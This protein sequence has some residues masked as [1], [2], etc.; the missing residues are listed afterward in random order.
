VNDKR[1]RDGQDLDA[2]V[3]EDFIKLIKEKPLAKISVEE[4]IE[5]SCVSKAFFYR[6]FRTKEAVATS[7][8]ARIFNKMGPIEFP[9]RP[10]REAIESCLDCLL[11]HKETL[12]PLHENG[13]IGLIHPL[14]KDRVSQGLA[15]YVAGKKLTFQAEHSIA[16]HSGALCELVKLWMD[17]GM[18][19]SPQDLMEATGLASVREDRLCYLAGPFWQ[20]N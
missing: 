7:C 20:T 16:A 10:V 1:G 8:L 6:R 15:P 11:S 19:Q 13:L 12:L 4:L 14:I 2:C 9:G 17:Y 3:E 5:K 18:E